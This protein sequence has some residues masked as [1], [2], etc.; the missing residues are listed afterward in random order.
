MNKGI[1]TQII[2]PVIDVAFESGKLPG[3]LHALEIQRDE[4]GKL[5]CEVAQHLGGNQV[6]AIAMGSTDGLKRGEEVIDTGKTISV[7]IGEKV[8]GRLFDLLGEP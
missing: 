4:E 6:R 2:G 8:L 5:V 3:L 7:P 1:I